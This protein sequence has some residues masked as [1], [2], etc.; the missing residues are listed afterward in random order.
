[1]PRGRT[2]VGLISPARR[3]LIAEAC[4][5]D[6]AS[7]IIRPI[8]DIVNY[9]TR[10]DS[11]V[12]NRYGYKKVFSIFVTPETISEA[13]QRWEAAKSETESVFNTYHAAAEERKRELERKANL[14]VAWLEQTKT[15]IHLNTNRSEIN[16]CPVLTIT[17]SLDEWG[18]KV[19]ATFVFNIED[20]SYYNRGVPCVSYMTEVLEGTNRPIIRQVVNRYQSLED[21]IEKIVDTY[22]SAAARWLLKD[23]ERV[24]AENGETLAWQ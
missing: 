9:D 24:A 17:D 4:T 22:K 19:S 13:R 12:R 16:G 23:Y 3:R 10:V 18:K 1:M 14:R 8:P 15:T 21:A 7:L 5:D 20:N 6:D 11:G 2:A